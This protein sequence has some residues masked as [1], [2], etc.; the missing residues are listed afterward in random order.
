MDKE[1]VQTDYPDHLSV[2]WQKIY[3]FCQRLDDPRCW[4]F[5]LSWGICHYEPQYQY[6]FLKYYNSHKECLPKNLFPYLK[7]QKDIIEFSIET[8]QWLHGNKEND[9]KNILAKIDSLQKI[10][11]EGVKEKNLEYT[12]ILQTALYHIR[13]FLDPISWQKMEHHF[14]M[15]SGVADFLCWITQW[16]DGNAMWGIQVNEYETSE[17][18]IAKWGKPD[19]I[20]L[21]TLGFGEILYAG[22]DHSYCYITPS[23]AAKRLKITLPAI[24]KHCKKG[25]LRYVKKEGRR[26]ILLRDVM[27][28]QKR[29]KATEKNIDNEQLIKDQHRELSELRDKLAKKS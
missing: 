1:T 9:L 6:P 23:E 5:I 17:K 2:S 18:Y 26:R 15:A 21:K 11:I 8:R 27:W 16:M 3:D 12:V 14:F 25:N 20:D 13:T 24:N 22:Q 29:N 28:L 7:Y 19:G 10:L 4:P